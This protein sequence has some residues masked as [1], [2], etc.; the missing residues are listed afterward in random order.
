M[1]LNCLTCPNG[2]NFHLRF[3]KESSKFTEQRIQDVCGMYFG[4]HSSLTRFK[5][6]ISKLEETLREDDS[7]LVDVQKALKVISELLQHSEG[8][9]VRQDKIKDAQMMLSKVDGRTMEFRQIPPLIREGPCKKIPR[10]STHKRI[11]DRHLF[12]FAGYLVI[13]EPANAM[14]R[15][16][17]KSETILSGATLSEIGEDEEI[18]VPHCFRIKAQHLCVELAFAS[19]K[20][21]EEWWDGLLLEISH[22]GTR[23]NS[24]GPTADQDLETVTGSAAA[25]WVKDEQSTMCAQCHTQFTVINRRHHCRVCGK[26]FC[27]S[28]SDYRAPIR[29]LGGKLK[30]VCVVDYY[31]IHQELKPP[32]P[33]IMESI[34][35]RT[36]KESATTQTGYLFWCVYSQGIWS[37]KPAIRSTRTTS[38]TRHIQL[39]LTKSSPIVVASSGTSPSCPQYQD[40]TNYPTKQDGSS[41]VDTAST[42]SDSSLQLT[43]DSSTRKSNAKSTTGLHAHPHNSVCLSR[44]SCVLQ[45]DTLLSMFAARADTKAKDQIPLIGTRLFF[46]DTISFPSSPEPQFRKRSA[47]CIVLKKPNSIPE[48]D[49]YKTLKESQVPRT[50]KA[51][52]HSTSNLLDCLLPQLANPSDKSFNKDRT[53]SSDQPMRRSNPFYRTCKP[54]LLPPKPNTASVPA[55][56][57][58]CTRQTAFKDESIDSPPSPLYN[59]TR[60]SPALENGVVNTRADRPRRGRT[61]LEERRKTK[62]VAYKKD[63]QP[64]FTQEEVTKQLESISPSILAILRNKLGFILLPMNTD[65]L[66][67]YFEAPSEEVRARWLLSICRTCIDY[68]NQWSSEIAQP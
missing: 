6:L 52:S 65:S 47:S 49:L 14:G 28:C 19:A 40:N 18:G 30:R 4:V 67:H 32:T 20:E 21:K 54:P 24:L 53:L 44:M 27:G 7:R 46:L 35:R 38:Q 56:I 10:R 5:L 8:E 41:N 16:Q 51:D 3:I 63:I 26:V 60:N 2:I 17:T 43:L 59:R 31:L 57:G 15:Y 36:Q 68:M 45:T 66:A 12:L 48:V 64:S 58:K 25:E 37:S 1:L 9:M 42:N 22:A 39:H 33:A 11:L 50:F 13:T 34:L 61:V 29:F 62:F 55:M 23:V